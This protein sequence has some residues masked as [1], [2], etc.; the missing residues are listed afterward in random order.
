VAA[1]L[2][3]V[4]GIASAQIACTNVDTVNA[5]A[6]CN[7]LVYDFSQMT[8]AQGGT[9]FSAL[10]PDQYTYYFKMT[11]GGLPST[12]PGQ[13]GCAFSPGLDLGNAGG[14]GSADG[15]ACYPIGA[16][17]QQTWALANPGP[18]QTI[19]ITFLGG[20]DGREATLLASCDPNTRSQYSASGETAP[21]SK[22][23]ELDTRTCAACPSISLGNCGGAP[24]PTPGPPPGPTPTPSPGTTSSPINTGGSSDEGAPI[25]WILIAVFFGTLTIY[26]VGGILFLKYNRGQS[27]REMVPHVDFWT[28]LPGL[29]RDG[30]VFTVN[31]IRRKD[32]TYSKL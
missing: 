17:S 25:G 5:K 32:T 12:T 26:F 8:D 27:G 30:A 7:G 31:K 15:T 6:T 19:T 29:I 2:A 14:Q 11:G 3:A 22:I 24:P 18:F 20:Q 1:L 13:P 21:Q 16:V 28:S 23:Y 10:G 9:A 4:V